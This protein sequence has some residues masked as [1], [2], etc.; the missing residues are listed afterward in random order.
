[1]KTSSRAQFNLYGFAAISIL[2]SSTTCCSVSS[3]CWHCP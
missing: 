3:V 2:W 1:V